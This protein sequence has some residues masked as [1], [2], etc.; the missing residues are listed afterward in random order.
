M[1]WFHPKNRFDTLFYDD[2]DIN[3]I[4]FLGKKNARLLPINVTFSSLSIGWG[5]GSF[6]FRKRYPSESPS[7]LSPWAHFWWWWVEP[8]PRLNWPKRQR[9]FCNLCD[10]RKVSVGGQAGRHHHC[11]VLI[12]IWQ[13]SRVDNPWEWWRWGKPT[14]LQPRHGHENGVI[15]SCCL[16]RPKNHPF[17]TQDVPLFFIIGRLMVLK[18]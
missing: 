9:S 17:A 6:T 4:P 7:C 13:P 14:W 1:I 3:G 18:P 10:G 16:Y 12:L 11:S 5:E 15:F 2:G 8:P